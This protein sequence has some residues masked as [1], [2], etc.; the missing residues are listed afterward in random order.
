MG[1][2]M[3][4]VGM[5]LLSVSI[6]LIAGL[7]R[8]WTAEA[9]RL[10]PLASWAVGFSVASLTAGLSAIGS[11]LEPSLSPKW[12]D[13]TPLEAYVPLLVRI[14]EPVA[15]YLTQAT[16]ALF[17]VALVHRFT[18]GWM[19]KKPLAVVLMVSFGFVVTGMQGID[20]IPAWLGSGLILGL[21]LSM[22]YLV[23]LRFSISSTLIAV[24]VLQLLNVARQGA[25]AAYPNAVLGAA[26]AF[27]VTAGTIWFWYGRMTGARPGHPV[28]NWPATGT[29]SE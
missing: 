28:P 12:A 4:I 6:G 14:L 23:A 13:Y 17:V 7:L 27:I 2:G 10:P 9:G 22:A 15:D 24:G 29:S 1:V 25:Y 8:Q 11:R 19:R 21:L 26:V 20:A 16:V 18:R 3:G 5:L